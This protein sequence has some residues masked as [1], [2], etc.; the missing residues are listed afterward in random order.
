MGNVAADGDTR[1][2][3]QLSNGPLALL[4]LPAM[5]D[6]LNV[7]TA[8]LPIGHATPVIEAACSQ[9]GAADGL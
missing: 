6:F 7:H 2:T 3:R 8:E 5:D 4:A 9:N 1:E